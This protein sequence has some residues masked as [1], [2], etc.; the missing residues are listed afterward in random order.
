MANVDLLPRR[1]LVTYAAPDAFAEKTLGLLARLGYA[2]LDPDAYAAEAGADDRPDAFLVDDRSLAEVPDDGGPPI[3]IVAL[4][5][6]HGVTG[7]D[8]RVMG[9]VP[10]PAG[11][12]DLYRVLQQVLE[13]RPRSSPRVPTHLAARCVADESGAMR[14]SILMLSENGCLL[15]CP[16]PLLLGSKLSLRFALPR[17]GEVDVSAEVAYQMPPDLGLVFSS[18]DAAKRE[19][20]VEFVSE[21]LASL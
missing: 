8:V 15:R 12:H 4:A 16:E 7:A 20:I 3:P 2:I 13:E 6:K 1:F 10:R 11:L 5:G 21:A 19:A 9:A 18:T 17:Y 14:G